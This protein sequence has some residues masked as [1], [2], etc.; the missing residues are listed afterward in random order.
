MRCFANNLPF[1]EDRARVAAAVEAGIGH[2]V[3]RVDSYSI[4]ASASN[5]IWQVQIDF[6]D[7][8]GGQLYVNIDGNH[9]GSEQISAIVSAA[10]R[11]RLGRDERRRS[12]AQNVTTSVTA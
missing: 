2:Y 6:P 5:E 1:P 7:E 11:E 12:A 3:T 8:S 10:I 9:R 4:V